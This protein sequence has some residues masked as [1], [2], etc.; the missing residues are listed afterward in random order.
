[1]V[2]HK[3]FDNSHL[4]FRKMKKTK[5]KSTFDGLLTANQTFS[6][7]KII[8]GKSDFAHIMHFY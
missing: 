6:Q 8:F 7:T 4:K 3:I 5:I 2:F 1:M